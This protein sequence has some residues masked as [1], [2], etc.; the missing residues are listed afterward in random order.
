M[1]K[2]IISNVRPS[3]AGGLAVYAPTPTNLDKVDL[4]LYSGEVEFQDA[5]GSCTANA[6]VS[7]CE[8]LLQRQ[9]KFVNLSRLFLYYNARMLENGVG[10]DG[11]YLAYALQASRDFGVCVEEAW[12]YDIKKVDEKPSEEAYTQALQY[13]VTRYEYIDNTNDET[14]LAGA[15]SALAEGFPVVISMLTTI[16][17]EM[18]SGPLDNQHYQGTGHSPFTGLHAV[19][20]IGY[21]ASKQYFI[22]ENSWGSSWGD[23]GYFALPYNLLRDVTE[24]WV[25]AEITSP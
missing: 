17:L 16:K 14:K 12:P 15:T 22:V 2:P 23:R 3:P 25:V 9:Q 19:T 10:L 5:I 13:R 4:R 8:I 18:V 20:I 6:I 7:A 11:A 1:Y 21:D 24:L